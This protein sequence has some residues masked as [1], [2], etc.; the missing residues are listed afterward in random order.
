[1]KVTIPHELYSAVQTGQGC[2]SRLGNKQ[3]LNDSTSDRTITQIWKEYGIIAMCSPPYL[4]TYGWIN[5]ALME[6]E[7]L[8][9]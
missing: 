9:K 5:M 1:M 6:N 8:K 4:S 3:Y 2:G 7:V